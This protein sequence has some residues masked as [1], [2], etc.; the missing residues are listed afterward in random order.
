MVLNDTNQVAKRLKVLE[1]NYKI[2][3]QITQKLQNIEGI[4]VYT[5]DD[6]IRV[7]YYN[8]PIKLSPD[9]QVRY[10][11]DSITASIEC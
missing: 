7:S 10:Y 4:R 1:R 3:K 8:K 2:N 9:S 11:K 5:S 6:Y